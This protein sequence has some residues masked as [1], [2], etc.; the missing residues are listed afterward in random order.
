MLAKLGVNVP[1]TELFGVGGR[2]LLTHLCATG[3]RFHSAFGQRIESLVVLIDAFDHEV[4]EL[5]AS[6]A[7]S[8]RDHT[9]YRAI[10]TIDGVG[11]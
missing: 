2:Q 11:P 6:I 7:H 4:N 10:H 8:L 9:G 3:P 5:S 1:M